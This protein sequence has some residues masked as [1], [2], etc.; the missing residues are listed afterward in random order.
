MITDQTF[1]F[2]SLGVAFRTADLMDLIFPVIPFV[3]ALIT[4]I[5]SGKNTVVAATPDNN[6][7]PDNNISIDQPINQ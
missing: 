6:I 5:I 2:I 1:R 7:P 3:L 4:K